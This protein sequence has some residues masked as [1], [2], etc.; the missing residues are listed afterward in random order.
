MG[1]EGKMSYNCRAKSSTD[2]IL[3]AQAQKIFVQLNYFYHINGLIE[4]IKDDRGLN[5][6]ENKKMTLDEKKSIFLCEGFNH[7][8]SMMSG[9]FGGTDQANS[10][11]ISYLKFFLK[12]PE[13]EIERVR[14][15]IC[16]KYFH[17]EDK[18]QEKILMECVKDYLHSPQIFDGDI[19]AEGYYYEID[20]FFEITDSTSIRIST[21]ILVNHALNRDIYDGLAKV[22]IALMLGTHVNKAIDR[23]FPYHMFSEMDMDKSSINLLNRYWE[24]INNTDVNSIR[25]LDAQRDILNDAKKSFVDDGI[26][27]Y[28][29]GTLSQDKSDKE[30]YL[31]K[32][33]QS[34]KTEFSK[35][36]SEG[37]KEIYNKLYGEAAYDLFI[38]YLQEGKYES[39]VET[40]I[41]ILKTAAECGH[42]DA[43]CLYADLLSGNIEGEYRDMIHKYGLA[44]ML[45]EKAGTDIVISYY[46]K[47]KSGYGY[48]RAAE[49]LK[50]SAEVGREEQI[51][52]MYVKA[53]SCNYMPA[54]DMIMDYKNEERLQHQ[55]SKPE[56]LVHDANVCIVLGQNEKSNYFVSTLPAHE[57]WK[58]IRVGEKEDCIEVLN[59]MSLFHGKIQSKIILVSYGEDRNKSIRD[60]KRVFE[61]IGYK[62]REYSELVGD[63]IENHIFYCMDLPQSIME[64]HIDYLQKNMG[65][66]Y[67][68]IYNG[69]Y[70]DITAKNLLFQYPL[71]APLLSE[72]KIRQ[73]YVISILGT[74]DTT[75]DILKNMIALSV[76]ENKD[77]PVEIYVIGERS[78]QI[79]RQYRNECSSE[80]IEEKTLCDIEITFLSEDIDEMELI[81]KS[82]YCVCNSDDDYVNIE[83]AQR[84]N[85]D[86]IRESY[87]DDFEQIPVICVQCK[88]EI[89]S[90]EITNKKITESYSIG[91]TWYE[92]PSWFVF[93]SRI[94]PYS[95]DM[96]DVERNIIFKWALAVHFSYYGQDY[97]RNS[98]LKDYYQ[99]TYGRDSSEL[100][101]IFML[102]RL[103]SA[104]C[105][106]Q[107]KWDYNMF[108]N[109]LDADRILETYKQYIRNPENL[110][111]HSI[112]E[113]NRWNRYMLS[114]NWRTASAEMMREYVKKGYGHINQRL[115]IGKLHRYLVPWSE[116]G[117]CPGDHILYEL[118]KVLYQMEENMG[119]VILN[120]YI[121]SF[122]TYLERKIEEIITYQK[123]CPDKITSHLQDN[124][125]QELTSKIK[126]MQEEFT[127]DSDKRNLID[128]IEE[129]ITQLKKT[130]DIHYTGIQREILELLEEFP[131]TYRAL[132][133]RSIKENDRKIVQNMRDIIERSR[134][135]QWGNQGLEVQ[136]QIDI[137]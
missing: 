119:E 65:E 52:R 118:K 46:I 62:C 112:L 27:N 11:R 97:D 133:N 96:I 6:L 1:G 16:E 17:V 19:T 20:R 98:V 106:N 93:G 122:K 124:I 108:L 76:M 21:E 50:N 136:T 94:T 113:H 28:I 121:K 82:D 70:C 78:K 18:N 12:N 115:D 74:G 69:D 55:Y 40:V 37:T 131:D 54:Y 100:S 56:C 61:Y 134:E 125:V 85:R 117:D 59:T 30:Y 13:K 68:P 71:F 10:V 63:C 129:C 5:I 14:R 89:L 130:E 26:T 86:Y 77:M 132:K 23:L 67:I 36:K 126:F 48:F 137:S 75:L 42:K 45:N 102:Y 33:L 111:I 2:H 51:L 87:K 47:S 53:F 49:C 88:D 79:E 38:L 81:Q 4:K 91:Y 107:V 109:D 135:L 95:Y 41:N 35:V 22:M 92:A 60:S 7:P 29:I 57:N 31:D 72:Q 123:S 64:L 128:A 114:R 32:C 34:R 44:K 104:R 103:Y 3:V 120:E 110:E 105:V 15:D 73:K 39:Q 127:K 24:L 80:L 83:L 90:E 66:H 84:I 101:A 116:I 99:S 8:D 58:I 43:N 9:F 25:Y